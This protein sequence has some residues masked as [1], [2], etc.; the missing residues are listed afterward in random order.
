MATLV[1]VPGTHAHTLSLRGVPEV[2][3][4]RFI[5]YDGGANF[6]PDRAVDAFRGKGDPTS[7]PPTGFADL[8][9]NGR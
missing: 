7:N 5:A 4:E 3:V 2:L 8:G 1:R 9:R 6:T